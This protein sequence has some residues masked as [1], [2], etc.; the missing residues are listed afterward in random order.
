MAT[1]IAGYGIYLPKYRIKLSD[2]GEVWG[3][4]FPDNLEKTV[5]FWDEDTITMAAEALRNGIL[6]AGIDE[7]EIDQLCL[8]TVTNPYLEKE[9]SNILASTIDA[10]DNILTADF[11]DSARSS[12][13]AIASCMKAMNSSDINTS[14]VVGSDRIFAEPGDRFE[15]T[16]SSG[17]GALILSE[18]NTIAEIEENYSYVTEF[19]ERY[20]TVQ[21]PNPEGTLPRFERN[22][23][24]I[25]HVTNAAKGLMDKLEK[26]PDDF[27]YAVFTAP[28]LDYP[29]RVAGNIGLGEDKINPGMVAPFVGYPGSAS[30]L[31]SL[32]AVLDK[33][34]AGERILMISYANGC[35]DAFSIL[36]TE[37]VENKKQNMVQNYIERKKYVD[38][39][40]Y[41]EYNKM[42]REEA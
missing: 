21:N 14:A 35:S 36:T 18:D 23:G 2:I 1:G 39:P 38:Y 15:Y 34:E 12:T 20:R 7:S 25:D 19:T 31:I 32:A 41:L 28:S 6:H 9:G 22:F 4:S 3:A 27:D 16:A 24:Y 42:L 40:M 10:K 11:T 33:A 30:V 13:F 37:E 29:S 8:G 17:A 5:P 26:E